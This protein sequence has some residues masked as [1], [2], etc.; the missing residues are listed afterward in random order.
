MGARL[1]QRSDICGG[2]WFGFHY[3]SPNFTTKFQGDEASPGQKKEDFLEALRVDEQ[4]RKYH[5]HC[6]PPKL[7]YGFGLDFED[8]ADYYTG[9]RELEDHDEK[10]FELL[11]KEFPWVFLT[12]EPRIP[13]LDDIS[14]SSI[15]E[16][17]ALH[18]SSYTLKE[19]FVRIHCS[20]KKVT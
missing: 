19:F 7:Y 13:D 10:V 15:N 8:C 3:F 11:S 18:P 9:R 17:L 14:V 20:R 12:Q 6:M 2:E 1:A 5:W 4:V 16:K